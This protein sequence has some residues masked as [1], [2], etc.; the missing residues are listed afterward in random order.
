MDFSLAT[1]LLIVSNGSDS[2]VSLPFN[3]IPQLEPRTPEPSGSSSYVPE[4]PDRTRF[5]PNCL[6]RTTASTRSAA[7]FGSSCSQIRSTVHPRSRRCASVSLS[8]STLRA[9][10]ATHQAPFFFGSVLCSGQPCQKQ[11][12]TNTAT[13]CDGNVTSARRRGISGTGR[14][15]RYRKPRACSKRR[16]IISASV[17][18][19]RCLDMRSEVRASVSGAAHIGYSPSKIERRPFHFPMSGPGTLRLRYGHASLWQIPPANS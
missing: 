14:S 17:S 15:T 16:S 19:R 9:N 6:D 12:S 13:R 2:S 18:R 1:C 3:S 10:F 11:P 4:E 7:D 5:D 8:R